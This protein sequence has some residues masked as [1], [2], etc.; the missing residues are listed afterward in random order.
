ML[1]SFSERVFTFIVTGNCSVSAI[2]ALLFKLIFSAALLLKHGVELSRS[3]PR[4]VQPGSFVFETRL[5]PKLILR[6]STKLYIWLF[7][8]RPLLVLLMIFGV[9]TRCSTIILAISLFM[10]VV[11][12]FRY[13]TI[14]AAILTSVL[15]LDPQ[16]NSHSTLAHLFRVSAAY[17]MRETLDAPGVLFIQMLIVILYAAS[18]WRK[19]QYNFYDGAVIRFGARFSTSAKARRFT[20]HPFELTKMVAAFMGRHARFVS[21]FAVG[22]EILIAV[23]LL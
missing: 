12:Y 13:H 10:E 22:I 14:I 21:I 23:L 3:Y 11:V 2:S 6:K 1:T 8:F 16:L 20:D 4:H 15:A 17:M 18:A 19:I 5:A 7:H 9:A